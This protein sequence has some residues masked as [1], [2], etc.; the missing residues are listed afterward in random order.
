MQ[1][2]PI[3]PTTSTQ[4]AAGPLCTD[5]SIPALTASAPS[6]QAYVDTLCATI[7][8]YLLEFMYQYD[9]SSIDPADTYRNSLF[10][11]YVNN[12]R[13]SIHRLLLELGAYNEVQ[14]VRITVWWLVDSEKQITLVEPWLM[15]S[16]D[17][18]VKQVV[19][20]YPIAMTDHPSTFYLYEFY[21]ARLE[22]LCKRH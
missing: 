21:S 4:P 9:I 17:E 2:T 7:R 12:L 20:S 15:P 11:E 6:V 18:Y 16:L 10:R 22:D 5:T 14:E 13:T 1:I 3:A 8:Q 19:Q